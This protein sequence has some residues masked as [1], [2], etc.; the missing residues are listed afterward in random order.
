MISPVILGRLADT[1]RCPDSVQVVLCNQM[2]YSSLI[3]AITAA[4]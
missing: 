3:G 1:A 2:Y 4:D